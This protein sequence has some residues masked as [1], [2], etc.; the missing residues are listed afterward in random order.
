VIAWAYAK[1]PQ[2]QNRTITGPVTCR[3]IS[4]A[5]DNKKRTLAWNDL[6]VT[7]GVRKETLTASL[8][9]EITKVITYRLRQGCNTQLRRYQPSKYPFSKKGRQTAIAP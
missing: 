6:A 3:S 4:L 8:T 7:N 2:T 5:V 1:N 9:A